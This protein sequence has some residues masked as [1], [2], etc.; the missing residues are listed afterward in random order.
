MRNDN[1]RPIF[2][3]LR[4]GR[5]VPLYVR[6]RYMTDAFPIDQPE[7]AHHLVHLQAAD[8]NED[9]IYDSDLPTISVSI[10]PILIYAK[11]PQLKRF[12]SRSLGP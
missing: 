12:C 7:V 3:S 11:Q 6:D 8:K 9:H 2:E 5:D 1:V 10:L 4:M